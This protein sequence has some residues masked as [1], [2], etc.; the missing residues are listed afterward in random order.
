[1]SV[2]IQ[3][4]FNNLPKLGGELER[5]AADV[6]AKAAHDVEAAVKHSM[7]GPKHGRVYGNHQA[8]APGEAP[9]IDTGHL[10]N[11][12]MSR[13]RVRLEW[14]VALG[15]EYAHGLEFG[16]RHI[17]PRSAL[18]PAVEK[19]KPSFIDAMEQIAD[20]AKGGR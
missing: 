20:R 6:V 19:D 7:E 13:Q 14:W 4:V 3:M 11:S 15:A 10:H 1:M 5:L 9:A 18:G 17:A 8:S 12:V 16:T 2:K